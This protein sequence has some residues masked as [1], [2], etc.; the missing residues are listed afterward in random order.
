MKFKHI[1]EISGLRPYMKEVPVLEFV[2][3]SPLKI[4]VLVN[5][6]FPVGFQSSPPADAYCECTTEGELNEN[7]YSD[8]LRD[9]IISTVD[10]VW[11]NFR[12]IPRDD[13]QGVYQEID[14]Y[15]QPMRSEARH[16]VRLL[17]W[18]TGLIQSTIEPIAT[19]KDFISADESRWLCVSGARSGTISFIPTPPQVVSTI[20][21]QIVQLAEQGVDEPLGHQLYREAW[22][23]RES[24]PRAAL[25]IAV[26]AAEVGLKKVIGTLVPE[27]QWLLEEIQ[28]P[29]FSKMLRKYIPTLKVRSRLTGKS[30]LPP[31][32]LMNMLDEAVKVRN[33]IVHAGAE[34]PNREEFG[35]IL[36]A[37]SD[38][39]WVCD[40]YAGQL[41][42]IEFISTGTLVAWKDE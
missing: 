25:V 18:R 22:H 32:G 19:N 5:R 28:T 30:V 41:K 7:K 40:M 13:I 10:G 23:L 35:Q 8:Y 29:P 21:E 34:P 33:K 6:D 12:D 39:L 1:L 2:L 26:A 15:I 14:R 11:V 17:R 3:G 36:D 20:A 42:V 37:I 24:N 4:H 38:F 9:S 31:S 27:A 16:I